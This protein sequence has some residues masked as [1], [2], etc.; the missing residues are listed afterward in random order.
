M[1]AGSVSSAKREAIRP[2]DKL[3]NSRYCTVH[4]IDLGTKS[5]SNVSKVSGSAAIFQ[6]IKSVFH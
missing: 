2:L 1:E 4:S 3:L 5:I 6:L